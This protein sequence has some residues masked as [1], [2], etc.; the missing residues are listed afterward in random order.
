MFDACENLRQVG[1][2]DVVIDAASVSIT[3]EQAAALEQSQMLGRHGAGNA[4]GFGKFTDRVSGMTEHLKNSQ[5]VRM[6]ERP[7]PFRS[8]HQGAKIGQ[9]HAC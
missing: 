5:P 2:H 9:S 3:V 1:L 7:E 6:S 4:A 8:N